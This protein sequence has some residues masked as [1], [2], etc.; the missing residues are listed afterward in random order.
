MSFCFVTAVFSHGQRKNPVPQTEGT[1][2]NDDTYSNPVLGVEI[3]LPGAWQV[4]D[5][6]MQRQAGLRTNGNKGDTTCRELFCGNPE[7]SIALI[8][9]RQQSGLGGLGAIFLAGYKMSGPY[10]N[11]QS[12][13]LK[14]LAETM[15]SSSL[16][17]SGLMPIGNLTPIRLSGKPAFRLL[18]RDQNIPTIKGFGYVSESN[19]YVFLLV[20]TAPSIEY[21][22]N[23]Q[24]AI[25]K[26]KFTPSE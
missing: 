17:A 3:K 25:E 24:I 2:L 20:G 6:E 11:R 16:G 23:L 13:P 9:K 18:V 21:S 10:L 4:F 26:M 15:T 8:S 5:K 12:Y 7:I 22:W 19:G 1:I 14:R